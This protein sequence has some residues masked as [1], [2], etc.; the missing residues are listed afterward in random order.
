M[1]APFSNK[2]WKQHQEKSDFVR[3]HERKDLGEY[4]IEDYILIIIDGI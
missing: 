3:F 4:R 1:E 2:G